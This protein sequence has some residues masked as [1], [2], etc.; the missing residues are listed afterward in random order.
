MNMPVILEVADKEL[1]E[2]K[3]KNIFAEVFDYFVSIEERFSTFKETSE[4]SKINRGEI[5]IE[6]ASQEMKEVFEIAEKTRLETDGYFNITKPNGYI[7]PAGIVKGLAILRASEIFKKHGFK[8]FYVNVAGDIEVSGKNEEGEYWNIGIQNP[9][10]KKQESIKNLKIID[11][12]IATSGNYIRGNHIYNGK[13]E[14][15]QEKKPEENNIVSVTVIGPN[16]LEADRFATAAFAMG[17]KGI[18]FLENLK[19]K[20]FAGYMIDSKGLATMTSNFEEYI[21]NKLD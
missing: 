21:I 5:K 15:G 11:S 17:E 20:N 9:F 19:D 1:D 4:I 13:I 12:G 8:N 14:S 7:D 2:E 16:I 3:L 6:D 18:Y 10:N